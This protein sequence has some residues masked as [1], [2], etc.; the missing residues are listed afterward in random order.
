MSDKDLTD[1]ALKPSSKGPRV[2]VVED[3]LDQRELICES[4]RM[5]FN[6]RRDTKIVGVGTGTECLARKLS[7]FDIILLDYNLPDISGIDL[8]ERITGTC[9]VPVVF[10]T[11]NSDIASAAEA[12][13]RGAQDYIVKLGDYLFALPIVVE[14]NIRLHTLKL[15]NTRLQTE[16][17]TAM[18]T[19][20]LKNTAL[21]QSVQKL[22]IMA[23]T[24]HLTGLSN[25]RVFAEILDRCYNEAVRYKFD[26]T[27]LMCDLDRYKAM[28][29]TLGHQVG[30]KILMATAEV[31]RA[32][33]R[34]SDYAARYGGD[35]FV[36]LL[37]HTSLEMAASVGERIC[38]QVEPATGRQTQIGMGVTLSIGISSLETD[39]PAS[40]D[41][42]VV[43]ADR[44]MYTAKDRGKN[45][46]VAFSEIEPA[47]QTTA[48]QPAE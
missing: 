47:H 41:A 31:I 2:L 48:V 25:R 23:A 6:D 21:E 18:E 20:R 24:D 15:E 46:I 32:N 3:D 27:C 11:G 5:H 36:I 19:V 44:A 14:K 42:L 35:E 38:E 1:K 12:I 7:D 8:L 9:D 13:H 17:T 30:D 22:R 40:A 4:L 34:G 29:D 37:P 16:L 26:L 39:R 10:V 33:L 43:M 28:N 45:C